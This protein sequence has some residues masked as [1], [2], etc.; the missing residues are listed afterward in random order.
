[1]TGAKQQSEKWKKC[2]EEFDVSACCE[3]ISKMMQQFC[4]TEKDG[5]DCM[6]MMQKVAVSPADKSEPSK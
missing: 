6:A 4:G 3:Q 5:F 1:M 2:C